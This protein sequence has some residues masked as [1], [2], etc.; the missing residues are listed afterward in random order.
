MEPLGL[1]AVLL[2]VAPSRT[3]LC[4]VL[5]EYPETLVPFPLFLETSDGNSGEF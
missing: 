5:R 2:G 4:T 1:R 3:Y